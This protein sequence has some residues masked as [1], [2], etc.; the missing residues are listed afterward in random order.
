VVLCVQVNSIEESG[1]MC[2]GKQ[3]RG[4]WYNVCR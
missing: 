1:T 3:Y 4:E 2:A